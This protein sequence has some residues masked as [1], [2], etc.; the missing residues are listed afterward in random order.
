MSKMEGKTIFF[1]APTGCHQ[2]PGLLSVWKSLTQ[3]VVPKQFDS[4][5]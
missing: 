3:R 2:E 1:E 4:V 5:T